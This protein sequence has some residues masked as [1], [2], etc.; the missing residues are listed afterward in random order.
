MSA[1]HRRRGRPPR[2]ELLARLQRF[3]NQQLRA[4][5][6]GS[7]PPKRRRL[8]APTERERKILSEVV[9]Q[10]AARS[11]ALDLRARGRSYSAIARDPLIVRHLGRV[12]S[13]ARIRQILT[14]A[15]TTERWLEDVKE[16]ERRWCIH[17]QTDKDQRDA[18]FWTTVAFP[19]LLVRSGL[20]E[21]GWVLRHTPVEDDE[22]R[23]AA[24][25][26]SAHRWR[27]I[28]R[29][30]IL[31]HLFFKIVPRPTISESGKSV[32][33]LARKFALSPRTVCRILGTRASASPS[34]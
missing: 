11:R 13:R 3:E 16:A 28:L 22:A 15:P 27:L 21:P 31:C 5:L 30:E 10:A 18:D 23:L 4:L 12:V 26:G 32:T 6:T 8:R 14:A 20:Y 1:A 19:L 24:E 34:Y 17:L 29:D 7:L 25:I 2:R 33:E 9:R